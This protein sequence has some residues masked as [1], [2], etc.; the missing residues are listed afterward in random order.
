MPDVIADPETDPRATYAVD[1]AR[2]RSW[3][4]DVVASGPPVTTTTPMTGAPLATFPTSTAD[5]VTVAVDRARAA[6]RRWSSLPVADRARVL[7]DLHD[8]VLD[9]QGE[10][11]DL[12]QLESGK[13]RAHAFEEVADVAIV[14]RHYARRGPALLAPQR[15]PGA[16]PVLTRTTEHHRPKG[17]VGVVAPWNYP[18][19]LAVTD[20]LPALLAGNAVVLRPDPQGSL[21]ALAAVAL[22]VE[23][24]VPDGLVQV[25]LGPGD[26][27]GAAVVGR[28]DYVCFT[29]STP[30]GRTVAEAAGRRLVGASLEL[31]G[32][33]T[34]YVADDADL[35][36]AVPG[37]LHACFASA[38]QLCVSAERL[39]VHEA[40][41]DEFLGRFLDAVARMRLSTDLTWDADMGS[42]VGE[43]QR[44]RVLGH[45]E[46]AV[47]KGARV[48]TGG[49]ARPDVGPYVVEPTVLEGVTSA[50]ACRDEET[51][52]P[53]VAVTRVSSDE[54]AVALA[55]DTEYGLNASVW[56]RDVRRGR[57]L[58]ARLDAGTVNVN[59]GYAAAWGSVGAPMGG[60]K[61]SGLGRRHGREG[62]LKYTE[63]QTVAVQRGVNIADLPGL[64]GSRYAAGMTRALRVLRGIGLP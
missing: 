49:R 3:L 46:D 20:A 24:G 18:L 44:D 30:T 64:S 15:R 62:L 54:A 55:N 6:R 17:V 29:G 57:S 51:F 25:V 27:T 1:P 22:L 43:A 50:M 16:L 32:K 36:R 13:A 60:M 61:A 48:L 4:R 10:L 12:V 31:G 56:T 21:T 23:A 8:L 5:D 63:S 45:V 33:N 2:V 58:A 59:E 7:L 42:L 40:V 37:V 19:T 9:R 26:P 52:G 28:T 39:A 47:A 14:C 38:G 41:A 53:V 34:V 11:L 35:R